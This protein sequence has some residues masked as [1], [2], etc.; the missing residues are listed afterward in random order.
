MYVAAGDAKLLT[1]GGIL[2]KEGEHMDID[3]VDCVQDILGAAMFLVPICH[4]ADR[5]RN[6]KTGQIGF[7]GLD[8]CSEVFWG[9]DPIV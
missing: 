1:G 2:C 3:E 9:K 5:D 4:L 6:I 8:L 7:G